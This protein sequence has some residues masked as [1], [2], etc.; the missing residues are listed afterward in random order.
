MLTA[1]QNEFVTRT[2]PGTPMGRLSTLGEVW[3]GGWACSA[4]AE[5]LTARNSDRTCSSAWSVTQGDGL[6]MAR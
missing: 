1:E 3:P 5:S 6:T 4:G 2:G